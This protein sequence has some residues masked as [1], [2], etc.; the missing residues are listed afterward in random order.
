VSVSDI[1][2]EWDTDSEAKLCDSQIKDSTVIGTAVDF[3]PKDQSMSGKAKDRNH[4]KNATDTSN[5]GSESEED[6]VNG[7]PDRCHV[8]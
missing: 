4:E 8:S 1:I 5:S 7:T 2:A 3:Q 6:I